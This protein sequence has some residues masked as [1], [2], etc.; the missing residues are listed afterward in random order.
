MSHYSH[1]IPKPD[2][3]VNSSEHANIVVIDSSDRNKLLY[4][5]ANEYVMH[6]NTPLANVIEVELISID[7]KYSNYQFDLS[8]NK[9][10]IQHDSDDITL[11]L[12]KGNYTTTN[13]ETHFANKFRNY[14]SITGQTYDI[15][16]KYHD[17]LNRFYFKTSTNKIMGIK[18]KG[19]EK[20]YPTSLYGSIATNTGKYNYKP[21]TNGRYFGYSERDFSNKLDISDMTVSGTSGDYIIGLTF[22]NKNDYQQLLDTLHIFDTDMTCCITDSDNNSH[23]ISNSDI[24]GFDIIS[25]SVIHIMVSS[26][27]MSI[28]TI[29]SNPIF[30]T[31]II[32]GDIIQTDDRDKYVLLDIKELNRLESANSN[33]H[34]SYVKIPI[35]HTEQIYFNN[36]KNYGT[37]KYFNPV[38]KLLDRLSIKIKDRNGKILDSGGL[39]HTMVFAIKCLNSTNNLRI[40]L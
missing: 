3:I 21:Y 37:I 4:K 28:G 39:D 11:N 9:L 13:M 35:N 19:S 24:K 36:A 20:S 12:G 2:N 1:M 10:Y 40:T 8:N 16:I 38:L 25:D 31:N 15:S 7:Y 27:S 22:T 32:I 14:K 33:I 23:T 5:N 30:Y 29:T 6:F 26:T 34:D 17:I 18:F